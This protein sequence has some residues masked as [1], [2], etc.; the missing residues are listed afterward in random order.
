MLRM[1]PRLNTVF[2]SRWKALWWAGSILITAYWSVP[3]KGEN[4]A[5]PDLA[6]VAQLVGA[7]MPGAEP[8]EAPPPPQHHVNPWA[9]DAREAAA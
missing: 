3:N 2:A 1:T 4:A 9:R 6:A 7:G 5:D 8:S